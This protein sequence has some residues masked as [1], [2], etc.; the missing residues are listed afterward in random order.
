MR[1]VRSPALLLTGLVAGILLAP[2]LSK[3]QTKVSVIV[4]QIRVGKRNSP[5]STSA[6]SLTR[7]AAVP[8]PKPVAPLKPTEAAE[9]LRVLGPELG[10]NAT[11][12]SPAQV[13]R[14]LEQS[15]GRWSVAEPVKT[16]SPERPW[17]AEWL[18]GNV[19]YWRVR[20][21]GTALAEA[22]G[23]DWAVWRQKNPLGAVL[24]LRE[25]LPVQSLDSAAEICGLFVTPGEVLFTWRDE[26]GRE[27]I[28]RSDRQPLGLGPG[29]PFIVLVG[30]NLRG[31][32][33]LVASIL[34]ERSG[35]ILLGQA[36][37]GQLGLLGETRLS[38]G[39]SVFRVK[40]EIL[41]PGGRKGTGRPIP[42]DV[43][44]AG[45]SFVDTEIWPG[46]EA[47]IA[48]TIAEVPAIKRANEASLIQ[49]EDIEMEEEIQATAPGKESEAKRPPQDRGLQRAGDLLRMIRK[50]PPS[51]RRASI[52]PLH[53][54]GQ[55]S[56]SSHFA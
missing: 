43:E 9:I 46:G 42:P 2:Q 38:S 12:S 4:D 17:V 40:G 22:I 20:H 8:A 49:Q 53:F 56:D 11:E 23:R 50:M 41:L 52:D 13:G 14:L 48:S 28:F 16:A 54:R 32:G 29:T 18:P 34:Q 7:P 44:L 37:G 55:N 25:C 5:P 39:R 51:S 27:K 19:A 6:T 33:E 1:H 31:A 10:A 3:I 21:L 47:T 24:D 36:T 30:P 45:E 35:A 15:G 26:A